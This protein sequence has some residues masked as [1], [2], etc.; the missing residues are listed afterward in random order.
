MALSLDEQYFWKAETVS[1]V[2]SETV[3]QGKYL[4]KYYVSIISLMSGQQHN[5]WCRNPKT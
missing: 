2:H 5:F 1:I 3:F 4:L